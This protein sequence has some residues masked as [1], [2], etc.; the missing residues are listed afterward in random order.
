MESME[1]GLKMTINPMK[2]DKGYLFNTAVDLSNLLGFQTVDK[3]EMPNVER[4]YVSIPIKM[5]VGETVAISGFKIKAA[6]K[7]KIGIPL[8][9]KIPVLSYLFG[10]DNASDRTS[11]LTVII[12]FS[13]EMEV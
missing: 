3:L 11:E 1:V 4:N 10:Y 9:I 7:K 12:S 6:D 8:L 5:K 13:E 2:L